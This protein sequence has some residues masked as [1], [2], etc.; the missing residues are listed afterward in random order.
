MCLSSEAAGDVSRLQ[1]I[2]IAQCS[3]PVE[4]LDVSDAEVGGQ[5]CPTIVQVDVRV[6]CTEINT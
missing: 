1:R 5:T 6:L 3:R 2:F 4:W